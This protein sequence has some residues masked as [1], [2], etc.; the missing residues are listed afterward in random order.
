M[1]S[2]SRGSKGWTQ[3]TLE[4]R[5]FP[6]AVSLGG[7]TAAPHPAGSFQLWMNTVRSYSPLPC[8][9][10]ACT[11]QPGLEE[12][13]RGRF[14][15]DPAPSR[16]TAPRPQATGASA[17]RGAGRE[18]VGSIGAGSSCQAELPAATTH[19]GCTCG[20]GTGPGDAGAWGSAWCSQRAETTAPAPA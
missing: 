8:Q 17:R 14:A 11:P 20:D 3:R 4:P 16:L 18:P 15:A 6:S 12:L 13:R 9:P 1:Q 7:C 5:G 10:A 19:P 2:R